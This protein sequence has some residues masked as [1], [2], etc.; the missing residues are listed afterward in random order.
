M[1]SSSQQ[2]EQYP[3]QRILRWASNAAMRDFNALEIAGD[4]S[5]LTGDS[6]QSGSRA[7]VERDVDILIAFIRWESPSP[8]KLTTCIPLFAHS[9]A[10]YFHLF[11]TSSAVNLLSVPIQLRQ[12]GGV[13]SGKSL[14]HIHVGILSY[15]GRVEHVFNRFKRHS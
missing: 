8:P 5:K 11:K 7:G 4:L 12:N 1:T 6:C 14:C 2:Y 10:M 15:C 13:F 3:G 9:A